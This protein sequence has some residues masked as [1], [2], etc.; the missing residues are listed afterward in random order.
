MRWD[1][2]IK[3]IPADKKVR[4]AEVGV[5]K[6]R[7]STKIL[8]SRP[9][10]RLIQVDRWKAYTDEERER[11]GNTQFSRYE[12]E[13]FDAA[14]AINKQ[15]YEL[16]YFNKR[17]VLIEGDSIAGAYLTKNKSLYMVFLDAL[18]SYEGLF[19]DVQA[20]LP[21]I[22]K[23]GWIGGHDY[24]TRPGV[25]RAVDEIFGERVETD[26]DKTWWVKIK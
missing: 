4:I 20:W 1:A 23:N 25:K 18:H 7:F 24:P 22:K 6:G 16:K 21:K 14:K 15:L 12:Q 3:R 5:W 19:A 26:V 10:V 2:A 9:L 8:I 11:E 17:M 13:K